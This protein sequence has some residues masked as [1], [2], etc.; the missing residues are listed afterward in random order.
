MTTAA[1]TGQIQL[2]AVGEYRIDVADSTVTFRT[3]HIFGMAPVS[4]SFRLREG[5]IRVAEEVTESTARAT[6]SAASFHTGVSNRDA[7]VRSGQYLDAENHPHITFTST[8][9]SKVDGRWVLHGTLTVRGR[10]CP[11]DVLVE[12]SEVD[13]PRVRLRASA[14]VDRYEYGITAMKGMTGR[15]LTMTLEL[16]ANRL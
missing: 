12:Q 15:W 1:Q 7:T 2:P 5:H 9:L 6:I 11:V 13:G 14:R 16:R 10:G 8:R 4:G 3:R